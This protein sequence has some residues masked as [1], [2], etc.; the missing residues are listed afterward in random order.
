[1]S[2]QIDVHHHVAAPEYVA[3]LKMRPQNPVMQVFFSHTPATSIEDMDKGGTATAL[4]SVNNVWAGDDAR[5]VKLARA[6]NDFSARLV[7]DH[8]GRF[9]MWGCIPMPL[10]D[11]SMKEIEYA[12]DVVK[13]DGIGLMTSYG[14]KW[15]GD[16]DFLPV[17]DELNRRKAVVFVHPTAPDCCAGMVPGIPDPAIEFGTDTTR[18]IASLLFGGTLKRCPDI[19]FIFS[20]AG[21]TM[22]FLYQRFEAL[23]KAKADK[24]PKE[25]LIPSLSTLHYDC[26]ISSNPFAM[27]P[28]NRLVTAARIVFGSDYPFRFARD[29]VEGLKGC[30]FTDADIQGI[31]RGNLERLLPRFRS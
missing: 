27:G 7:G 17:M 16:P 28:L 29:H 19:R 1:M 24:L 20:H 18:T 25:G 22:P 14:T 31:H 2:N 3:D 9:A 21:G 4:L 12:L 8:K 11:A 23:A 15:L 13:A 30:G 5:A 6:C 26:A 10:I